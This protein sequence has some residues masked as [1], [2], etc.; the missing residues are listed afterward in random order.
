MRSPPALVFRST[1]ELMQS[2]PGN[3]DS[4]Q[5]TQIQQTLGSSGVTATHSLVRYFARIVSFVCCPFCGLDCIYCFVC[6][7]FVAETKTNTL[8]AAVSATAPEHMTCTAIVT[9]HP[10]HLCFSHCGLTHLTCPG[11]C[12]EHEF[13]EVFV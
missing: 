12:N 7:P 6:F 5:Q 9:L 1:T 10:A 13:A 8:H 2:G 4:G 3:S 11:T